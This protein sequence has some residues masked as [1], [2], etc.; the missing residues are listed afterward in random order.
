MCLRSLALCNRQKVT[1]HL[2]VCSDME[3]VELARGAPSGRLPGFGDRMIPRFQRRGTLSNFSK[4]CLAKFRIQPI[5][6]LQKTSPHRAL[7]PAACLVAT[8]GRRL[9]SCADHLQHGPH[10]QFFGLRTVPQ[11]PSCQPTC[12]PRIACSTQQTARVATQSISQSLRRKRG[13]RLDING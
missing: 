6:V 2:P 1:G 3:I 7:A 13:D 12:M 5:S 11:L 10:P 4:A 8:S 9:A